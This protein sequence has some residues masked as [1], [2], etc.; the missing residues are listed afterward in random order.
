MAARRGRCCGER[1]ST[2]LSLSVTLPLRSSSSG[3]HGRAR[4]HVLSFLHCYF[5][6]RPEKN[7]DPGAKLDQPHALALLHVVSGVLI[8]HDPSRNQSGNL[9]ERDAR[10]FALHG[11]EVLLVLGARLLLARD[12][13]M[14]R[15]IPHFGDLALNRRPVHMNIEDV[16]KDTDT[17]G[18]RLV[19]PDRYN[20][21]VRRR[22]RHRPCWNRSIG[23]AKEVQ[24]ERGHNIQRKPPRRRRE[25]GHDQTADGESDGVVDAVANHGPY[26][27]NFVGPA[28]CYNFTEIV[29]WDASRLLSAAR[30]CRIVCH[31]KNTRCLAR[32]SFW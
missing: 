4:R 18:I 1:C 7:V 31:S 30:I 13:E 27:C 6:L 32:T 12:Q 15:L 23:V 17:G 16:Q 29:E 22:N 10:A 24:A 26:Y 9:G 2:N 20:L 28:N 8:K 21:T 25:K 3:H 14:T 11:N 19:R 5:P